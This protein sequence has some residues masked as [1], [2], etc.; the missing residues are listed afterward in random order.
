MLGRLILVAPQA[1]LAKI[2]LRS[3][4]MNKK[5]LANVVGAAVATT[6]SSV[7]VAADSP[8]ALKE[9]ASG[10][11]QVAEADKPAGEMKCGE[12]KCGGKMTNSSGMNCGAMK[13]DAMK[14]EAAQQQNSGKQMEGKCAGMNMSAP[15]TTPAPAQGH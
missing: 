14:N 4:Q 12:G 1:F 7:A 9:L 13:A 10:Y 2:K 3:N 15:A 6:L 11:M 8:F 5:T